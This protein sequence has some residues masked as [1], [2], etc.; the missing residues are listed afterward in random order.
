MGPTKLSE[1]IESLDSSQNNNNNNNNTSSVS[2]T[3]LLGIPTQNIYQLHQTPPHQ[4]LMLLTTASST[5]CLSPFNSTPFHLTNLTTNGFMTNRSST[6]STNNNRNGRS[7]KEMQFLQ[8]SVNESDLTDFYQTLTTS[9]ASSNNELNSSVS[10]NSSTTSTTNNSINTFA[11]YTTKTPSY[12]SANYNQN[13]MLNNVTSSSM[14]TA[15]SIS[16]MQAE[17]LNQQKELKMNENETI[18]QLKLLQQNLSR[19]TKKFDAFESK[20]LHHISDSGGSSKVSKS[21]GKSKSGLQKLSNSFQQIK[22][23]E[24]DLQ[25]ELLTSNL[26]PANSSHQSQLQNMQQPPLQFNNGGS[27]ISLISNS[28]QL[29]NGTL[30]S[31]TSVN[32]QNKAMDSSSA[33]SQS[34]NPIKKRISRASATKK[35]NGS[36]S[37]MAFIKEENT[38]N[39]T[40]TTTST[41][42]NGNNMNE[43]KENGGE[44]F[45]SK[46]QG[47]QSQIALNRHIRET[48]KEKVGVNFLANHSVS[49]IPSEI[50]DS[51]K[52]EAFELYLPS[53]RRP[54]KAWS[55]AMASLRCLKRELVKNKNK[56]LKETEDTSDNKPVNSSIVDVNNNNNNSNNSSNAIKI[57]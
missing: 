1:L 56:L 53:D 55:L 11:P 2:N 18:D 22:L 17:L 50:M 25:K 49:E 45:T 15:E 44:L 39:A 52:K 8:N 35:I 34:N 37:N 21:S 38:N 43:S 16:S 26:S 23:I 54:M 10:S 57:K 31:L 42:T 13:Q 9:N 5:G 46:I 48:V 30:T 29:L 24:N 6:S 4:T 40:S 7:N 47:I 27:L 3:N 36:D 33:S 20:V 19:L 12:L 51:I 41:I 28:N 32:N 14:S